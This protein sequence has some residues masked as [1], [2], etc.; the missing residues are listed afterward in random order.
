[1][2]FLLFSFFT[3]PVMG[4]VGENVTV[5]TQ[6]TVGEVP[7]EVLNVSIND[8]AES[9]TLIANASTVV[10][11]VGL[12]R[13]YNN[14]TG[15][16]YVSAEF[17]HSSSSYGSSD[18]NNNHYTNNSCNITYNFTSW[19][20]I[21][22]D[23]Y[24]VLGNCS[25]TIQYYSDPGVWNCTMF[26]ND[27]YGDNDTNSDDINVSTLL[28]IGLP[29]IINYGTVNATSVSNENITNITN[30]GNVEVNLSLSGYA[31][32]EGDNLSMNCT[33]GSVKNISIDFEQYNL[34]GS[35]DSYLT[36]SQFDSLY[37]NLTGAPVIKEFNLNYRH[38]DTINYA[39]NETYW[40]M[41]VPIGVAGSCSGNIIFGAVQY[42]G[43]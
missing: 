37:V 18:D 13:D 11:C 3:S 26:A 39:V 34:T 23:I 41:Y 27:T 31:M 15:L 22:D 5:I 10:Y 30:V 42:S 29:N 38:N 17:F 8:G 24:H 33:L 12:I 16:N 2:L 28:A 32:Y 40:R 7:P 19:G 35:N 14:E 20:G 9:I 4:G 21:A 1:L 36:I 6:L 43:T 25:F